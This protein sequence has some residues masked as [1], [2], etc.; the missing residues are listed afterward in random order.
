MSLYSIIHDQA[1]IRDGFRE[2]GVVKPLIRF[3]IIKAPSLAANPRIVGTAFDYLLRFFL[4]RINGIAEIGRWIAESG[5]A[6]IGFSDYG[7]DDESGTVSNSS[8]RLIRKADTYIKEAKQ[9]HQAYLKTGLVTDKLLFACLRL[10]Y[11]DVA[12][13]AGPDRIDWPHLKKP[14]AK[15]VADL[16]ALL[17]IVNEPSFR[18][19]HTCLLNPTFGAA[20]E[21]VRGADADLFIDDCLIDIKTTKNPY[22]DKR[23]FLQLIGYYLLHGFDGI[24]HG[25]NTKKRNVTSLAIYFARYGFLWKV[26]VD[27][28]LPPDSVPETA[29]WFFESVCTSED[30][31]LKYLSVFRGPLAKHLGAPKQRAKKTSKPRS[32]SKARRKKSISNLRFQMEA[33]KSKRSP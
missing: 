9:E 4:Q 5:V 23:D 19:K 6:R 24:G 17:L 14:D 16:R 30:Q 25:L 11:L 12:Y 3:G 29:K 15:D 2:R 1:A 32:P 27:D 22:F 33:R 10:A 7:Y 13:R 8:N 26:A 21:L 28:I 31:R 20:T 18:A